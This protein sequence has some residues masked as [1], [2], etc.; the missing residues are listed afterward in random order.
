MEP[1]FG[2]RS[3]SDPNWVTWAS[4]FLCL[5]LSYK[6]IRGG[7]WEVFRLFPDIPR[8]HRGAWIARVRGL[9]TDSQALGPPGSSPLGPRSECFFD[10]LYT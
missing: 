9:C 10:L 2:F 5:S 6:M 4:P 1:R 3:Q 7:R 8:F